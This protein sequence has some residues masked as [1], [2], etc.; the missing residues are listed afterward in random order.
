MPKTGLAAAA[1]DAAAAAPL[2]FGADRLG[3]AGARS[4]LTASTVG[5]H[6]VCGGTDGTG[7]VWGGGRETGG[8]SAAGSA[9]VPAGGGPGELLGETSCL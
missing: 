3:G 9:A 2:E 6:S 4:A 8:K 7:G 1:D 5:R